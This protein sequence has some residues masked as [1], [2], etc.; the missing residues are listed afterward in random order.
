MNLQNR[1]NSYYSGNLNPQEREST[2]LQQREPPSQTAIN[3]TDTHTMGDS[4]NASREDETLR[5][6]Q[7]LAAEQSALLE[8]LHGVDQSS[9][10]AATAAIIRPSEQYLTIAANG[11]SIASSIIKDQTNLSFAYLISFLQE[12]YW[13]LLRQ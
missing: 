7:Q 8:Q 9:V 5:L 10:Q 4:R 6:L 2:F 3:S 13:K 11:K 1:G 12:Q